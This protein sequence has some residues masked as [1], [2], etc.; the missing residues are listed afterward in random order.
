MPPLQLLGRI[1]LALALGG[2]QIDD[3]GIVPAAAG[4]GDAVLAADQ[5][6]D[7]VPGPGRELGH[8]QPPVLGHVGALARP[9]RLVRRRHAQP[10]PHV[11]RPL[12]R[13]LR[14]EAVVHHDEAVLHKVA[15]L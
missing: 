6:A 3:E 7:G 14:R 8:A 1:L 5:V 4:V 9:R 10:R 13:R 2:P 11:A 12:G 15:D